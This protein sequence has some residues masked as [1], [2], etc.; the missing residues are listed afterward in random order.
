[1][2]LYLHAGRIRRRGVVTTDLYCRQRSTTTLPKELLPAVGEQL[3]HTWY[4]RGQKGG[5]VLQD[6]T[7]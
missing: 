3:T 4:G 7:Y 5:H 6:S 1:M 2:D